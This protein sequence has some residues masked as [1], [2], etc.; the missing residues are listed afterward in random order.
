MGPGP[1]RGLRVVVGEGGVVGGPVTPVEK[2]VMGV[3]RIGVLG[4]VPGGPG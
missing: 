4:V 1:G 2:R 3:E